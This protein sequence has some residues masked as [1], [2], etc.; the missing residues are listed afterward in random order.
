MIK[1]LGSLCILGGGGLAWW[2][3]MA[4]R[5]RRRDALADVLYVLRRMTEEIRMTRSS[6]PTLWE[7]AAQDCSAEV[8]AFFIKMAEAVRRGEEVPKVWE[9]EAQ[10]LPLSPQER[11]CVASLGLE[12]HGDEENICKAISL[13]IYDLAKALTKLQEDR[14]MEE[15]RTTALCFSSAA[16]L[17]ILL[18]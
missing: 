15:Q 7:K 11:K 2:L 16:L 9:R 10:G 6:L 8:Q 4:E 5:R 1:L 12:L 18:I 17:I 14:R 3:Q 13:V